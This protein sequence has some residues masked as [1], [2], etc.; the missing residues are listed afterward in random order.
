MKKI[1]DKC[2]TVPPGQSFN[3]LYKARREEMQFKW[4]KLRLLAHPLISVQ[5]AKGT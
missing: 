4:L 3:T 5:G 2:E 1:Q